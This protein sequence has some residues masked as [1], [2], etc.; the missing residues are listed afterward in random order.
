MLAARAI[1]CVENNT[2]GLLSAA[3][4]YAARSPGNIGINPIIV[5][6]TVVT[7]Q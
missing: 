1:T 7:S 3:S 5:I 6:T 2:G 4:I